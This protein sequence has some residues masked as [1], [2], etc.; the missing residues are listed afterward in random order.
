MDDQS[1]L[2]VEGGS[3][4]QSHLLAFLRMRGYASVLATSVGEALD[5]LTRRNFRFTLLDLDLDGDDP[6]ELVQRLKVQGGDP[7]PV[8][9]F[10][11]VPNGRHELDSSLD[12]LLHAPLAYSDLDK[13]I[14]NIL[15]APSPVDEDVTGAGGDVAATATGAIGK[16]IDLWRSPKMLE[17]RDIINDAAGVDVTVLVTGETGTGKE[18]VARAIHHLSTRRG[19]PFVKVNCAAMPRDLLESELFGHERGAFTGAHKLKIGKFESAHHGTIFL[20]EI[21]D[22]HSSLQAKLLHVLQDG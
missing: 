16:E 18:V 19:H 20:D 17:V 12:A 9:G 1:V 8:I 6:S 5:S 4:M 21:G 7:G 10:S 13:A 14:A 11:R 22:L 2:I 3:E 15:A